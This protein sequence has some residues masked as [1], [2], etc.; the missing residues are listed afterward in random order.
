MKNRLL[1]LKAVVITLAFVTISCNSKVQNETLTEENYLQD[2]K[3]V[4]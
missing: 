3:S 2:R 4:V 1:T